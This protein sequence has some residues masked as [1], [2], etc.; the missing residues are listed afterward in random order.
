MSE[1]RVREYFF[2]YPTKGILADARDT[3]DACD[4]LEGFADFL[5]AVEETTGVNLVYEWGFITGEDTFKTD[6][7][8]LAMDLG[9]E[10][11]EDED[12]EDGEWEEVEEVEEE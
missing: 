7:H 11:L 5:R 2:C 6:D 12:D 9:F 3:E 4:R 10:E 8:K 1:K